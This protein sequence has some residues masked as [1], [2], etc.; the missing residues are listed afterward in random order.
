MEAAEAAAVV[1]TKARRSSA[2]WCQAASSRSRASRPARIRRHLRRAQRRRITPA[3]TPGSTRCGTASYSNRFTCFPAKVTWRQP[4]VTPRPRMEGIHTA[5]VL[6][7]D[8][9]EIY[10]DDLGRVKVRFYWDHRGEATD[11]PVGLG[12]RHPALGRQ[13][14]GRAVHS[15]RRHRGRGRLRRRRSRSAD[16]GRRPLQRSRHADL[17]QGRQDQ[18]R[19]PHALQPEGRHVRLQRVHL[20]RQEGQRT[21]LCSRPRR[22]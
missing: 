1:V 7:P 8:G 11:A 3:T 13:R 10:T 17:Q 14:L 15:A 2:S 19:L 21:H 6:G 20:R 22:T 4:L 12:A 9:E 5:L 16:R 18:V